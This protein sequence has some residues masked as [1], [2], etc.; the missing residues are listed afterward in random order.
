MNSSFASHGFLTA[1]AEALCHFLWQGAAI[2]IVVV[3]LLK[4]VRPRRAQTRYTIYCATLLAMAMCPL[5]TWSLLQSESAPPQSIPGSIVAETFNSPY[6]SAANSAAAP[7]SRSY[8]SNIGIWSQ[9]VQTWIVTTWFV[10]AAGC[11]LRLIVG[12]ARLRSLIRSGTQ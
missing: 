9:S 3:A 5:L 4:V 11:C 10:G 2:W 12:A 7:V 8:L 6:M 1:L